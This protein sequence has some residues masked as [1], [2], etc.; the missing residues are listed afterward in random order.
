M[1]DRHYPYALV[2][3]P[4][5]IPVETA[6]NAA[7]SLGREGTATDAL[8][9]AGL[10]PADVIAA[11]TLFLL[12]GQ[13][14][15]ESSP[16]ASKD[17]STSGVAGG[18]WVREQF[19]VHRPVAISEPL[20]VR[21][22]IARSFARKGRQY[23]VST[24][25]TFDAGGALVVSSCTTGLVRYRP[26]PALADGDDGVPDADVHRAGVDAARCLENPALES[27]CAAR[28]GAS[29]VVDPVEVTL[30]MMRRRDGGRSRNPIHTEPEEAR[31]AGLAAPI[32]GGTH[33]MA[34]TLE[35]LMRAWG[36]ESLL[37]GAAFDARWHS[38]VHAGK[39]IEPRAT[40]TAADADRVE[41]GLEVA[42]EGATAMTG[43]V[44][45]PLRPR[46]VAQR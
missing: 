4:F 24:S 30:E 26:D 6:R 39:R 29:F 28:P 8:V 16:P 14:R 22:A 44:V 13:P 5:A 35:A 9:D 45:V 46:G 11:A 21:G 15:A 18:V 38:P 32:A 43:S 17:A 12:G 33:V 27:L 41:V 25:Q 37:H 10:V 3:V 40:V 2:A 42:C 34:F 19:T 23:T 20:E 7:A 36:P 31:R 1:A